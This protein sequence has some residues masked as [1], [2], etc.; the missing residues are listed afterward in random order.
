MQAQLAMATCL[1]IGLLMV[2]GHRARSPWLRGW[3]GG[4]RHPHAFFTL[5]IHQMRRLLKVV[6][7]SRASNTH[8]QESQAQAHGQCP[9]VPPEHQLINQMAYAANSTRPRTGTGQYEG[10]FPIQDTPSPN[11][12]S[13]HQPQH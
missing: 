11:F 8:R 4:L 10:T 9:R 2:G 1:M 6:T 12:H 5:L 3:T 13:V 7:S